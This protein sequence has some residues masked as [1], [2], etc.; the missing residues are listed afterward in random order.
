MKINGPIGIIDSGLGGLSVARQISRQLPAEDLLYACDCGN[1]PWG[2]KSTAFI[3]KR[4]DELVAFILEQG[5]KA[6]V[7]ACNTATAVAIDRLRGELEIPVVGIEPAV[8]SALKQ[9]RTSVIGVL[10]TPATVK[11]TR[12]AALV[13][14]A[15]EELKNTEHRS[16]KI[17]STPAPGLMQ[18]VE[19]GDL[20]G[21]ETKKLILELTKEMVD[22]GC[23]SI[24]LGCT[25]YPFLSDSF[26]E[27]LPHIELY[28]SA[29]EVASTLKA[30]LGRNLSLSDSRRGS[31]RFFTTDS[32][33]N[34]EKI[35]SRLWNKPSVF[36]ELP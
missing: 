27:L 9:S 35:L 14:E 36:S 10:A 17:I 32:T 21:P 28:D 13:R 24:V 12:Y 18:R 26:K 29:P 15:L 30:I 31:I 2:E 19:Q 11:S 25:H 34:R 4:I 1:A 16:A 5:C 6:L 33:I 8:A 3:N 23:D 20:D 7:V 22:S